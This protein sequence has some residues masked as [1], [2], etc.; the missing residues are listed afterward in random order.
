LHAPYVAVARAAIIGFGLGTLSAACSQ[1]HA[2]RASKP[3]GR[4]GSIL[5]LDALQQPVPDHRLLVAGELVTTDAE[6]RAPLPALPARYDV[7][8]QASYVYV[9]Q[10]MS[11]RAPVIQLPY[12]TF[13][14]DTRRVHVDV[15]ASPADGESL[16][17]LQDVTATGIHGMSAGFN[18]DAA[19]HYWVNIAWSGP[20]TARLTLE[21]FTSV[22]DPETALVTRYS[23]YARYRA[24][25][26]AGDEVSWSPEFEPLPFAEKTIRVETTLGP[27]EHIFQHPVYVRTATGGGGALGS[28][29]NLADAELLVP[30][31]PNVTFDIASDTFGPNGS[32]TT[33]ARD[34][35]PGDR[36]RLTPLAAPQPLVPFV[37][38]PAE[39][40]AE[41]EWTP[42]ADALYYLWLRP[43]GS[44]AGS[45]S[46]QIA[47][48]SPRATLPDLSALGI[49]A[50]EG[51]YEWSPRSVA[52]YDSI[53]AY[54]AG[55]RGSRQG[56]GDNRA[57]AFSAAE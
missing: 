49:P 28:A 44:G 32:A 31:L 23:G 38:T 4:P 16:N 36:V 18:S 46:Y 1:S 41:F 22:H 26:H 5:L 8:L 3:Q 24:E 33:W 11:S 6:G 40:P 54:A 27:D 20:E 10:G 25:V 45:S 34:L 47:S 50:P 52:D 7:A 35:R 39:C 13:N 43:R 55:A 14:P 51:P 17:V 19:G 9:F 56:D 21:A 37:D 12:E 30:D 53:D 29:D 48:A 57:C 2:E 42:V 15:Y